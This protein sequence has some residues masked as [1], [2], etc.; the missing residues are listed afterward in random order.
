MLYKSYLYVNRFCYNEGMA[1][2]KKKRNKAYS[3]E[4]A[5]APIEPIVHRYKAVD[6]GKL[7]QWW[8]EKKK[9]IKI[10]TITLLVIALIIWMIAEL[11][12]IMS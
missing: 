9:I 5:A 11:I 8:F 7:G 1:K 3:G 10:S 2:K 12:R 6:R 4:D